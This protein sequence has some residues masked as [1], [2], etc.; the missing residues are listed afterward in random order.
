MRELVA[1]LQGEVVLLDD[2][3][4]GRGDGAVVRTGLVLGR[5]VDAVSAGLHVGQEVVEGA[6]DG[7]PSAVVALLLYGDGEAVGLDDVLSIFSGLLIDELDV[8]C[9]DGLVFAVSALLHH[10]GAVVGYAVER[11]GRGLILKVA[12]QFI[13]H[14]HIAAGHRKL[15]L[16]LIVVEGH[17]E[18]VNQ[19]HGE[20]PVVRLVVFGP[21]C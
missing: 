13:L 5:S 16:G 19:A 21:H 8:R 3:E 18:T 2:G 9:S 10:D 14:A 6:S 11:N 4:L 20:S 7:S 12:L 17:L 15:C 1:S